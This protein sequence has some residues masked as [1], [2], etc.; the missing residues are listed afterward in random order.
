[1][2]RTRHVPSFLEPR[3]VV[4]LRTPGRKQILALS[5]RGPSYEAFDTSCHLTDG[6]AVFLA[7]IHSH[8]CPCK[9]EK[10]TKAE[11]F[12][13]MMGR[14]LLPQGKTATSAKT[15]RDVDRWFRDPQRKSG[16]AVV[17]YA[18]QENTINHAPQIRTLGVQLSRRMHGSTVW[19]TKTVD[20]FWQAEST[21]VQG[22]RLYELLVIAGCSANTS[23]NGGKQSVAPDMATHSSPTQ[24]GL[25]PT[26]VF[27]GAL[28]HFP[29]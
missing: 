26:A 17:I 6:T 8:G 14:A 20:A 7:H 22:P 23:H 19:T 10:G 16:A 1:M 25:L 9:L 29:K 2:H 28:R 21:H 12:R 15:L 13:E 5:G 4:T 24:R 3:A 18:G 11:G 27:F